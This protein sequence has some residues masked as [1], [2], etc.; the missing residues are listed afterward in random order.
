MILYD[1]GL[2]EGEISGGKKDDRAEIARLVG[3]ILPGN[4]SMTDITRSHNDLFCFSSELVL[5]KVKGVESIE[6]K[7][8]RS[9][10]RQAS[11]Q[12]AVLASVDGFGWLILS[13]V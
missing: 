3:L 9:L 5:G 4:A 13:T 6:I 12:G 10:E 2:G 7:R 1:W 8:I 11:A